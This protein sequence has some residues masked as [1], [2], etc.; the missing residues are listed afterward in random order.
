MTVGRR[1][2]LTS[3]VILA[4]LGCRQSGSR[5]VRAG[6]YTL[7]VAEGLRERMRGLQGVPEIPPHTGM[8]FVQPAGEK[9]IFW[10]KGCLVPMDMVFIDARG[11]VQAVVRATPSTGTAP[12]RYTVAGALKDDQVN[13]AEL[14]ATAFV[15]EV[16]EGEGRSFAQEAAHLVPTALSGR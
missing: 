2:I 16:R 7:Q 6:T 8:V 14:P 10:M 4:D 3:T 13:R 11:R 1:I 15:V 12:T 5:V 9:A